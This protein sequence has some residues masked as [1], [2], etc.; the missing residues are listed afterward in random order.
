MGRNRGQMNP[1]TCIDFYKA[2]HRRQYPKGTSLVYS[3]FTARSSNLKNIPDSLF[4]GGTIFFGLQHFVKSYL[5][6][7]LTEGFNLLFFVSIN[8]SISAR[9]LLR[10]SS[11]VCSRTRL[12]FRKTVSSKPALLMSFC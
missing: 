2:D 11:N 10:I 7:T 5:I 12:P 4:L 3:N 6:Y 8:S 1:L 9:T